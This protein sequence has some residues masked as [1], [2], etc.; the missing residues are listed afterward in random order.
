MK[1]C[2]LAYN[3]QQCEPR[4]QRHTHTL[5]GPRWQA[6]C[7]RRPQIDQPNSGAF[8]PLPPGGPDVATAYQVVR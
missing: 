2:F 3:T 6:G 8:T 7:P 4:T 5:P 1:Y